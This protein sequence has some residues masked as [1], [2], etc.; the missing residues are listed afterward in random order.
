MTTAYGG[1]KLNR[2]LERVQEKVLC[3]NTDS[4]IY[5]VKDGE[6]PLE[7]GDCLDDLTDG[8]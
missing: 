8:G 7:L 4:M 2:Y 5:V 1:L 6:T 3:T